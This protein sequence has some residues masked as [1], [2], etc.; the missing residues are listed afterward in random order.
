MREDRRGV[1]GGGMKN[2]SDEDEEGDENRILVVESCCV[3][4]A[5]GVRGGEFTKRG[6]ASLPR[7]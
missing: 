5:Y 2:R 7:K 6:I 4:D 1:C 3:F